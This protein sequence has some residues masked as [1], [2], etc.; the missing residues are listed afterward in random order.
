M[1]PIQEYTCKRDTKEWREALCPLFVQ[2]LST[3]HQARYCFWTP[4]EFEN[5]MLAVLNK[6][7]QRTLTEQS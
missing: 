7:P 1:S 2:G 5:H 6:A 4:T 3:E